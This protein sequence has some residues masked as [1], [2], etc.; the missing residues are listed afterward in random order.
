ME[1]TKESVI[2]FLRKEYE[3]SVLQHLVE[4]AIYN[5]LD[6]DWEDEYEDEQDAYRETGRGEAESEV[7]TDI[8]NE[9][10]KQLGFTH[11]QYCE[12]IGQDVWDTV[13]EVYEFLEH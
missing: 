8:Q 5:Y 1:A 11:E 7:S 3:E 6:E 4:E 13:T 9:I 2:E 12:V 10:L